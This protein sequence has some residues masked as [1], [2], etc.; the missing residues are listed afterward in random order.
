MARKFI[1]FHTCS[2]A[3]TKNE[4]KKFKWQEAAKKNCRLVGKQK[5][6]NLFRFGIECL[7]HLLRL[8]SFFKP[9][10]VRF[11][12]RDYLMRFDNELLS[13]SNEFVRF[14]FA[15][16]LSGYADAIT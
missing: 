6:G 16:R 3:R 13:H 1:I 5:N 10:M 12:D 4:H 15:T 8:I 2:L 14:S 11:L 7:S 9:A